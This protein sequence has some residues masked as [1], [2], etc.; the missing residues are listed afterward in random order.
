MS[1]ISLLVVEDDINMANMLKTKFE[2]SGF[3]VTLAHDVSEALKCI[4]MDSYDVAIVDIQLPDMNGIEL[5]KK[6]KEERP[7]IQVIVLTGVS[8]IEVA[9]TAIKAGAYDYITKPCD[10]NKLQNVITNA[11]KSNQYLR[12]MTAYES[13]IVKE[14][15]VAESKEMRFIL[16]FVEKTAKTSS[17]IIITGD[18][19]TGKELIAREIH[20][21]SER[22]SEPFV[23]INCAA[24]PENLFESE[25]FGHEKGAFTDAINKKIGLFE[26][27]NKGTVFLDEISEL[28][29]NMQVKLLRVLQF[30]EFRRVG[31]NVT[32]KTD[33]RIIAATNKNLAELVE[34]GSFREDLYYRINVLE[35]NIPSLK[36]RKKAIPELVKYF[37]YLF[38]GDSNSF[39][40]T[41]KA[42]DMLI[43]YDWPGNVR[44]LRN[45]IE[46]A[47]ILA[48][49][50][51]ITE[52]DL[53]NISRIKNSEDFSKFDFKNANLDE[54]E[55]YYIKKT[56][57]DLNGNKTKTAQILGISIQTLY[58]KLKN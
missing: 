33:I 57:K 19:G 1:I 54:I 38:T 49:E 39:S 51:N 11:Y 10:L 5:L 17:T 28:S 26:I 35:I 56:L 14:R 50:N 7:F 46:R 6:L 34:K 21:K 29:L 18:S 2:S 23:V 48:K 44:E 52:N 15:I 53:N 20:N 42:M 3:S 27:A 25:L 8:K 9:V 40:I 37:I 47:I 41:P 43:K 22:Y 12:K 4:E 58:N 55:M 24:L 13:A 36:K 31:S 30:K 45:T 32:T 16:D